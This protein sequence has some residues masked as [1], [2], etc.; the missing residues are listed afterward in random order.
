MK[1]NGRKYS[2]GRLAAWLDGRD[3]FF[4]V[5]LIAGYVALHFLLRIVF[6]PVLGTDDV[7]I[8]VQAQELAWGYEFRQPPLYTWLQWASDRL[9]GIGVHSHALLRYLLLFL[10]YLFLYLSARRLFRRHSTAIVATL[11]L[12]LTYPFAVSIHQGVTHSILLSALMAASVYAF[13]RLE[14]KPTLAAYAALGIALGLGM[15][16]KYGF[17]VFAAA[18][19]GAAASLPRFRRVLLDRRMLVA[20]GIVLLIAFAPLYWLLDQQ[21]RLFAAVTAL[22]AKETTSPSFPQRIGSLL[23]LMSAV[24][25]FLAPLWLFLLAFFPRAFSRA[26][27]AAAGDDYGRLLGRTLLISLAVL[28]IALVLGLL[29]SVHPRWMHAFLLLFP[30][31]FFT[32]AENAYAEGVA[33]PGYLMTLAIIPLLVLVLW[34]G[35]TYLAPQFGKTTRFHAPYDRLAAHLQQ[36]VPAPALIIAEDEYLAGNLRLGF[37]QARVI[38][39]NMPTRAGVAGQGICLLVWNAA[40]GRELPQALRAFVAEAAGVRAQDIREWRGLYLHSGSRLLEIAYLV[41]PRGQCVA[42]DE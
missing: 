30:L 19:L 6:S 10:T 13:I 22:G 21:D 32:R 2:A 39:A 11:S 24:L 9:V 12:S 38:A 34:A 17:L 16:S 29:G 4:F 18:F 37:P 15:F 42:A 23:S 40:K 36:A 25:Q 26:A 35:Q 27:P 7:T 33:K 3:R 20:A 5:W 1:Q 14:A 8:A 28:A 41:L 31:Y